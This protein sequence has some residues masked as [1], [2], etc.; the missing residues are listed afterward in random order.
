MIKIITS[1][2]KL[3]NIFQPIFQ[4]DH[5]MNAKVDTYEM[6]MRNSSGVF[7][8]MEFL[9]G[10]TT[11]EGNDQWITIS[12]KS[13]A[14][15]LTNHPQRKIYINLEPCQMEF[16]CIW[17]FLEEIH[18]QYGSQVAI[19]ITERRETIH[20]LDYLDGEILRL[21]KMGFELAI[22]DVCAGSNSYAFIV[23]QL[24]AIQRI[25]LSLLVF[26]NEDHET[27]NDFINAW[28]TFAT[29]HHLDFVIEGI[30]DRQLAESFAGNPTV[31]QQGF[32]WGKGS[33]EI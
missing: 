8:G 6:L 20:S 17:R 14:T 22:D 1:S 7:P 11:Q 5:E 19:E 3:H 30:A 28:L 4:V 29:H 31:L 9:Q 25:K 15:A 32:Y 27:T 16:D 24:S 33:A 21:K 23:R 2:E 13:L 18:E 10:L 26:K 12:K